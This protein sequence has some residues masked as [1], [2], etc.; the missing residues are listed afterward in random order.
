MRMVSYNILNGGEGRADPLAE[1]IEANRPDMVALIEAD[2]TDVLERIAKR[3]QMDYIR[4][5]GHQ[6]AVALLSRWAILETINHA[7]LGASPQCLLQATVREPNGTE[8]SIGVTHF[9]ARAFEADEQERE[10]E[11]AELLKV[12]EPLRQAGRAHLLVGDF[13]ANS[14]IQ[15]ID[16]Q[17]VKPTTR[18]AWEENG[19]QIPRRVVQ[20]ILDAGYLDSF[21]V[22]HGQ[23][24]GTLASFTTQHP[25]QR[26][27]YAFTY[28]IDP[29]RLSD[30]WI[31][32]DRLAKYA[33]DHYPIGVEIR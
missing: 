31:E 19:G 9:H 15:Q 13:N 6:H 5:E 29:A 25:G 32:Q 14:P 23:K 2:N 33:S 26:V 12:F 11:V 30:A 17:K 18:K 27:D 4:A 7:A 16:P 22:V 21:V 28:G 3:L 1:V 10:R 24:A 8:W 20:K